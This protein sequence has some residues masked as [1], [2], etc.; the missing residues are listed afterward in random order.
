MNSFL[1]LSLAS[2]VAAVDIASSGTVSSDHRA[3]ADKT[4]SPEKP[5]LIVLTSHGVK[6]STGQPTGFYLG[7]VT[8]PM[9]VF[10]RAGLKVE[11]ASIR[12]GEPPVD[13]LK[14]DDP[15]NARYWNDSGFR[16]AIGDT[17]SVDRI[18]ASKYS[19]VLFAGGHGTMWDFADSAGVQRLTREIYEAGGVVGAVCHG[20]AALVNVRLSNGRYLVEGR[21]VAAFTDDEERAVKLE[22][23]VPYLLASTLQARG[24][25]HRPAPL[26]Q[27]QVVRD[28]RLVTGQNPASATGLAESMVAAL[29]ETSAGRQ[30]AR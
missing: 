23:V 21:E 18:D 22:N 11:F 1:S 15:I 7:E 3:A 12:G 14:L 20:P 29:S 10:E 16:A 13:G 30:V 27:A 4:D 24:A 5:V 9:A 17:P 19:A 25:I 8:H 6:G 28:G 2:A 26:W